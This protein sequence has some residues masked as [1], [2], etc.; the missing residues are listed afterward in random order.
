LYFYIHQTR[1]PSALVNSFFCIRF[2]II[3]IR[4]QTL[5]RRSR[6]AL[7]SILSFYS[8]TFLGIIISYH[9]HPAS[10][11]HPSSI[12]SSSIHSFMHYF[13]SRLRVLFQNTYRHRTISSIHRLFLSASSASRIPP[14]GTRP[15]PA[16][17]HIKPNYVD[18]RRPASLLIVYFAL[19]AFA[20]SQSIYVR[21]CITGLGFPGNVIMSAA[22]AGGCRAGLFFSFARTAPVV[23][24]NNFRRPPF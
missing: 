6:T 19:L 5:H 9:H 20:F 18:S 8:I 15:A 16:P 10:I 13:F 1:G 24:L 11:Q 4:I 12:A 23:C 2:I 3:N 14:L 7:L 22:P 21:A 17:S